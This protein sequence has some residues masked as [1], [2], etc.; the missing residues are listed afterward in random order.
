MS[1]HRGSHKQ[2]HRKR[3]TASGSA[4]AVVTLEN[5]VRA[6]CL[7]GSVRRSTERSYT[8]LTRRFLSALC[9]CC[10]PTGRCTRGLERGAVSQSQ[11]MRSRQVFFFCESTAA[12][13]RDFPDRLNLPRLFCTFQ[14]RD[15]WSEFGACI[16]DLLLDVQH[17]TRPIY[18][19]PKIID[20]RPWFGA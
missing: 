3:R 13:H 6:Q 4:V 12:C 2:L 17:R 7:R 18:P 1:A 19:T 16:P 15:E 10:G 9:R 8:C 20:G 14:C 11:A 5:P